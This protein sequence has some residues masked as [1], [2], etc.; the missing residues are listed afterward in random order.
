MEPWITTTLSELERLAI[1]AEERFTAADQAH[2]KAEEELNNS[3]NYWITVRDA[4][5]EFKHF[6]TFNPEG[7][8]P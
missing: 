7:G 5:K 6:V 4:L 8:A 1:L 2:T 3:R